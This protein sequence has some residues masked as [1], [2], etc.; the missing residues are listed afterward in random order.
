MEYRAKL[1]SNVLQLLISCA[2]LYSFVWILTSFLGA[3]TYHRSVSISFFALSITGFVFQLIIALITIK[4]TDT[5]RKKAVYVMKVTSA[6]LL[7]I[8]SF[9]YKVSPEYVMSYWDF[10]KFKSA[11]VVYCYENID[12]SGEGDRYAILET[13][14]KDLEDIEDTLRPF[15]KE[16]DWRFG[17]YCLKFSPEMFENYIVSEK[18]GPEYMFEL[19][20]GKVFV[21]IWIPY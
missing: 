15:D 19:M 10:D 2:L 6:L 8:I 11:S 14:P 1:I 3:Y 12:W 7:I 13:T 16:Q 18:L 17:G 20:N 21:H 4:K 9:L 5:V